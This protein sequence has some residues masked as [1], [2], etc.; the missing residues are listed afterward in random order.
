M[1]MLTAKLETNIDP[2][3]L[4]P[5]YFLPVSFAQMPVHEVYGARETFQ[6]HSL[7]GVERRC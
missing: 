5:F 6:E 3:S 1:I 4:P 7:G 2:D